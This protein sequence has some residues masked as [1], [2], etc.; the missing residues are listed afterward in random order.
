MTITGRM[1]RTHP[2]SLFGK[3]LLTLGVMGLVSLLD[4]D[5]TSV[6]GKPSH[7]VLEIGKSRRAGAQD[8]VLEACPRRSADP[9]VPHVS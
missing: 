1:S 8:H 4:T 6:A 9:G 3:R 7:A 5:K 2:R